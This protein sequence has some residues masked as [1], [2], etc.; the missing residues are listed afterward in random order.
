MMLLEGRDDCNM[1]M[2]GCRSREDVALTLLR[3]ARFV[4][5]RERMCLDVFRGVGGCAVEVG[6]QTQEARRFSAELKRQHIHREKAHF[7][8]QDLLPL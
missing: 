2:K 1:F 3:R 7:L 8:C 4:C 5:W 6:P